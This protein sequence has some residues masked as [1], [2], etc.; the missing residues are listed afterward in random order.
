[1][2]WF[3]GNPSRKQLIEK[4]IKPIKS[5]QATAEC[6]AHCTRGNVLWGVWERTFTEKYLKP[7]RLIKCDLMQVDNSN[8][9]WGYKPL[10]ESSHPYYY[11]CPLKYLFMV[12]IVQ[13]QDW[14]EAVI[15]YHQKQAL[16]RLRQKRKAA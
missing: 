11:T 10:D 6:L 12:P 16:K 1:M 4:L 9:V 13:S 7:E 8:G 15:R 14:R 5:D 3:F 2:R